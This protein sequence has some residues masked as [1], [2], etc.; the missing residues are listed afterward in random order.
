MYVFKVF[1]AV[2]VMIWFGIT[3]VTICMI[4]CMYLS[5]YFYKFLSCFIP[6]VK[7]KSKPMSDVAYSRPALIISTICLVSFIAY[8]AITGL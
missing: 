8:A 3:A 4:V 2:G 6:S 7:P 5:Y 1:M